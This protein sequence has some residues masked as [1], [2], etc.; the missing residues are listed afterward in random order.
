[1]TNLLNKYRTAENEAIDLRVPETAQWV[2]ERFPAIMA[3]RPTGMSDSYQFMPSYKIATDL[4]DQFGVP[5]VEVGQQFSRSRAPAG[6]EHF[7]KFRLPSGIDRLPAVGDSVPEIVIMN[8]HNGRST[9][10]AYAGIFRFV[11]ANGMVVSEKSFGQIKIRH[12]GE[13]NNFAEFNKVLSVMARRMSILDNRM[14]RMKEV[15][16]TP[17]EQNQ[18]AKALMEVRGTPDWLE[19]ADSLAAN[20]V[21]DERM[22]NG[23]RSLWTT[24]NTLQ[25]NLTNRSL[26]RHFENA[27]DRSIRPLS[28]ARAHVLTNERLWAGLET[29][30]E[31]RFPKLAAETFEKPAQAPLPLT[32]GAVSIDQVPEAEVVVPEALPVAIAL[33]PVD[34]Q[35]EPAAQ[36]GHVL[37]SFGQLLELKTF[38]EMDAITAEE[39][40][41]LDRELKTK[42]SKRKS[43]LKGKEKVDA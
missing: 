8:S 6:Q 23:N 10:R 29:F 1:M 34:A 43:Y 11:C 39:Y 2:G 5:L 17:H 37:R 19:A 14:A 38:A 41:L 25:E 7:M 15:I 9:I 28:G 4:M 32:G 22:E 42:I 35:P 12:F 24:F 16:L 40:E 36:E 18:L 33:A 20:R 13:E 27:R 31:D 26:S 3:K 30:I 21:D